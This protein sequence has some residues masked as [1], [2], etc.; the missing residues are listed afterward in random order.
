MESTWKFSHMESINDIWNLI[1]E[2]LCQIITDF[3]PQSLRVHSYR[4]PWMTKNT[5]EAIDKKRRAWT[6]LRNCNNSENCDNYK[7]QRNLCIYNI[8]SSKQDYEKN[9]CLNV[10]DKPKV[11]WSYIKSKN[12]TRDTCKVCDLMQ[13]YGSLTVNNSEKANVLNKFFT[14]V[15]IREN[16]NNVPVL[17]DRQFDY[18]LDDIIVSLEEVF[19]KLSKLNPSKAAGPDGLHCKLL[20]ELC[21]VLC[22]PLAGFFNRSLQE[23]EVPDQWRQAHVSPIF[24]KGDKKKA[25]NYRPVSLTC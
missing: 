20:Y 18:A 4:K 11:F 17:Q 6:K 14:S 13:D 7:N 2:R 24:K 23:D 12:K 5:A 10:K 22:E 25:E 19:K 9:I 3:L 21:D 15:F 16:T 8:R 1:S